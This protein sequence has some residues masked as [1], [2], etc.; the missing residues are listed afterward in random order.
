V[1]AISV[2]SPSA[3][4]SLR[5]SQGYTFPILSDANEQVIGRWDLVHAHGPA[6][7]GGYLAPRGVP[8]R[9]IGENPLGEFDGRFRGARPASRGARSV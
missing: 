7:R 2:D 9:F 4:E 5:Q 1:I 6:R 3:S 8:D